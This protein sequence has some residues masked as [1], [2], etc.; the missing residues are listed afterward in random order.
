MTGVFCCRLSTN[1]F[2]KSSS[3]EPTALRLT[4]EYRVLLYSE[5][6]DRRESLDKVDTGSFHICYRTCRWK[7]HIFTYFEPYEQDIFYII[8]EKILNICILFDAH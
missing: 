7:K 3:L 6:I 2:K 8:I 5:Y 4:N 1:P